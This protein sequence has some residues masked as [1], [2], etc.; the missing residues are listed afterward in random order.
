MVCFE[1]Y[2]AGCRNHLLLLWASLT[3]SI[4]WHQSKMHWLVSQLFS[5]IL[6]QHNVVTVPFGLFQG[7]YISRLPHLVFSRWI[8]IPELTW[9]AIRSNIL[10]ADVECD[11]F[12]HG[13]LAA[14][15]SSHGMF[16]KC[17]K[18]WLRGLW[19]LAPSSLSILSKIDTSMS[20][21][22]PVV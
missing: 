12:C 18:I 7:L 3:Y 4:R 16:G 20:Q 9:I 8:Q 13:A 5:M 2:F 19:G 14:V 6:Q 1:Q 17:W 22:S 21:W 11:W 15:A 10:L